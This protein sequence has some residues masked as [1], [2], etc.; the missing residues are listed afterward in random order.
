M[1]LQLKLLKVLDVLS[2]EYDFS[3]V[4]PELVHLRYVAVR[5][6]EAVSLAKLRNLQTII[7]RR[8]I[9]FKSRK[10]SPK[11]I[12]PLDIWTMSE[13]RQVDIGLP[14]YIS[15]PLVGEQPLFLNNL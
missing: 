3:S 5:I 6:K 10:K 14:L 8:V 1:C 11:L 12:L 2:I 13:I 15:N 9:I 7:L 4:I